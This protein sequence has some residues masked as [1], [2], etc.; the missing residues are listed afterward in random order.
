M[1]DDVGLDAAAR[2]GDPRIHHVIKTDRTRV[3]VPT[4]YQQF[5]RVAPSKG[6]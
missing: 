2:A 1:T 3:S 5:A 6:E 4:K